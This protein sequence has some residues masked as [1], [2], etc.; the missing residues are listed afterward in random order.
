MSKKQKIR[1]FIICGV[2]IGILATLTN[3]IK[4]TNTQTESIQVTMKDAVL[5]T[6]N[7][8][9]FL[10]M[11]V[12]PGLISAFIITGIFL[13]AG[14]IIRFILVPRFKRVPGKVQM[15]LESIVGLFDNMAKTNSPQ[16][17][18]FLG[19]YIFTAGSY[20]CISTL[21]ELLGVQAINT[22]GNPVSLPAPL[23]DINGAIML[24]CLSYLI[25]LG[26]GL[27]SNGPKGVLRALKDFSL[28]ISMSFRL[29]G[30][31]LSGA[32]VTELVYYY[33]L[34]RVV[35]PV[36][37]G[38][39]FTILHALIQAYVL[40]TLTAVFYGEASE[41]SEKPP[42]NKKENKKASANA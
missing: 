31:L 37:V 10:G 20:I 19:A 13:V 16:R 1:F 34:T 9:H 38:V 4:S 15:L 33:P 22:S 30:A 17:N 26:G 40:T 8:I 29:F 32:L 7:H 42:K 35:F 23:S 39:L 36:I 25:I 12:N 21:F 27:V 18:T 24:G 6:D 11:N 5:H 3:I 41:R 28:P 2:I 14:L